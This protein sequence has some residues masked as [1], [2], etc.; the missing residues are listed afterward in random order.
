VNFETVAMAMFVRYANKKDRAGS[1]V[2]C[3]FEEPVSTSSMQK[4]AIRPGILLT[5]ELAKNIL[6]DPTGFFWP[7]FILLPPGC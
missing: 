4:L 6:A 1:V 7:P 2:L 5:N 3:H